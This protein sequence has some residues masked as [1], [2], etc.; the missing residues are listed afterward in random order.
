MKVTLNFSEKLH[1]TATARHFKDIHVD[2]PESFHGTDLGP[3][4]IEY[5]LI[6]I[7]GCLGST[8][9]YCLN[10]NNVDIDNLEIIVDG[11]LKHIGRE[12]HLRL[13]DIKVNLY[14]T[15]RNNESSEKIDLCI[16]IFKEHC[17]V[18]DSIREGIPIK[19]EVQQ[20]KEKKN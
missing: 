15:T 18:T 8:L 17:V 9:V 10:R 14:L 19:V 7:G 11:T 12:K 1:F 4:S 6:G 16:R 20:N 13:I 2:E 3:S 5:I